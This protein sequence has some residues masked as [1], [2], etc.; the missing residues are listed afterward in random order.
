MSTWVYGVVPPDETYE[1]MKHAYEACKLAGV[2]VPEK[3][4]DFFD[5]KEPNPKGTLIELGAAA[6]EWDPGHP[7]SGLEI[8]LNQLPPQAKA[9]R[10]VNAW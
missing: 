8:W 4:I 7:E 5:G 9:I 3:I 10:F 1:R 6:R 2:E